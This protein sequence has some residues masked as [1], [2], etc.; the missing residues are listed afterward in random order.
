MAALANGDWALEVVVVAVKITTI[1]VSRFMAVARKP[2]CHVTSSR[3]LLLLDVIRLGHP[4]IPLKATARSFD[5]RNLAFGLNMGASG[6]MSCHVTIGSERQVASVPN[7][8]QDDLS[9]DFIVHERMDRQRRDS[10]RGPVSTCSFSGE[11]AGA[12]SRDN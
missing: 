9:S 11:L 6:Q 7:R 10:Y 8:L 12:L 1:F 2:G 3:V 5:A 4:S